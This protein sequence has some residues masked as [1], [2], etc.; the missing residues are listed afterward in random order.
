MSRQRIRQDSLELFL[1][2]ICNMF[3]GFLFLMLFVVVSIR[4]TRDAAIERMQTE[5]AASA[6]AELTA[7]QEELEEL[8]SRRDRAAERAEDAKRFIE[9]LNDPK[10]AEIY[11]QTLAS[12][13][14]LLAATDANAKTAREIE[15]IEARKNALK[16][17]RER[18]EK[19]LDEARAA[20]ARAQ[21]AADAALSAKARKTSTPQMRASFKN[22]VA[23]V[24]KY[25]RLYFWHAFDGKEWTGE[26]NTEDFVVVEDKPAEIRTEPKPWHGVDL[27][28]SDVEPALER[29]FANCSPRKDKIS[30][31]VAN[32]SYAEYSVLRDFLKAREYDL[33]P[34]VGKEGTFV[35]DQGGTNQ[36]AE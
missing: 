36:K 21:D 2:A 18:L 13:D 6:R 29:A 32:D 19:E 10:I 8:A 9:R 16:T 24:L 5:R 25:G 3:G 26:L 33:R 23:V 7:L 31:V 15:A 35:A 34:I 1:D 14:E 4:A 17:D 20:V 27:N 12:R 28:A 30:I 22:E 11:G